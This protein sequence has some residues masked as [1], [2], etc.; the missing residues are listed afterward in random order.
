LSTR[1]TLPH[2]GEG[3]VY[4]CAYVCPCVPAVCVQAATA[5]C[6]PLAAT[7]LGHLLCAVVVLQAA[8]CAEACMP[9]ASLCVSVCAWACVD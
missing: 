2:L 7:C 4:V 9:R 5:R 8:R 6:T 3:C 1:G